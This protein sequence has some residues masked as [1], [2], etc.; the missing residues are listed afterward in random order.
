MTASIR[1]PRAIAFAAA[2]LAAAGTAISAYLTITRLAGELPVC[3]PLVGC[4]QVAT[5]EYGEV[6]GIPIAAFGLGFSLAILALILT[7]ARSGS[8]PAALGAYGLGLVGIVVV[9]YLTYLELFVIRAVCVWCVGYAA[10]VAFGWVVI[11]WAI[12]R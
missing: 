3:G 2:G 9:A 10:T 1:P 8:R 4:E 5:S 7:W 6:F 11:A 12:R